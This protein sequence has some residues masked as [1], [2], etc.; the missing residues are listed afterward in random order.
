MPMMNTAMIVM[1]M[2]TVT[3]PDRGATVTEPDRVQ[4]VVDG[5]V[6]VVVVVVVVVG[7]GVSGVMTLNVQ[8]IHS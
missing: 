4:L 1:N 6:S 8:H 7:V 5:S 2:A 3:E